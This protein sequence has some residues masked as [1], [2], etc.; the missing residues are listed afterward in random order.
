M[1]AKTDYCSE[2]INFGGWVTCSLASCKKS[3]GDTDGY[4]ADGCEDFVFDDEAED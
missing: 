3:G 1:S 4:C 2:C